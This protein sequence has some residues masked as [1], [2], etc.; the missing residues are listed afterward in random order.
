MPGKAARVAYSQMKALPI[1]YTLFDDDRSE[2][3]CPDSAL[4]A[5]EE[6]S[7]EVLAT[8]GGSSPLSTIMHMTS[9]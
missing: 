2:V 9:T 4:K 8:L 5:S 6:S 1:D 7:E 3:G